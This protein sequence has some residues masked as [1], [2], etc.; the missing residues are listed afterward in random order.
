M[1]HLLAQFG[2]LLP[3]LKYLASQLHMEPFQGID[4]RSDMGVSGRSAAHHDFLSFDGKM[5]AN[6]LECL[7]RLRHNTGRRRVA[8]W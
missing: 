8:L 4:G 6:Q 5:G 2:V 7:W 1:P 3:V